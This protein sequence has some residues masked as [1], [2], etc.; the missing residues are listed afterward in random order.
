MSLF[1]TGTDTGVGKTFTAVALLRFLRAQGVRCAGFKPICCG[2]RQD[3]EMLLAASSDGLTI[4][5]VNPVWLKTPAAP[6][7]AAMEEGVTIESSRLLVGLADLQERFD[8][9]LVEGVGGWLVPIGPQYFVSDLAVEMGLPV[10]VVAMNRLGCLNH[11]LLTVRSVVASGLSCRGVVLNSL[12]QTPDVALGTNRDVLEKTAGV[13]IL[14]GLL[15][16]LDAL[17][18]VWL[19]ALGVSRD[20][21]SR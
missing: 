10:M 3:A 2:D 4:D 18:D 14:S 15:S 8:F 20:R 17:P 5:E 13:P 19:A 16:D 21:D 11:T 1:L 6:W 9:V 12:E 7:P